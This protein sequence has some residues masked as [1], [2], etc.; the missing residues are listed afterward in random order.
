MSGWPIRYCDGC[1]QVLVVA[2]RDEHW[3]KCHSEADAYQLSA[4]LE[5]SCAVL[6]GDRAGEEVS[7]E[8]ESA[9]ATYRRHGEDKLA[10]WLIEHAKFARGEPSR[11]DDVL[12]D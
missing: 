3:L 11:F 6:D 8:L 9:A 12:L 10:D 5:T 1:W 2:S 4:S 7:R